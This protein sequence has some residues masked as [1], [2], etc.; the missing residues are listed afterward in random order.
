M[1]FFNIKDSE[2][3]FE[4]LT[5]CE[6]DVALVNAKGEEIELISDGKQNLSTIAATYIKGTINEMELHFSESRDAFFMAEY[7]LAM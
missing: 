2:K 3:F 5:G 1:K 4:R 6:G 7:V